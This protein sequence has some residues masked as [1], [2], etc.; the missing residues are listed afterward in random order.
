MAVR[1]LIFDFDGLILDTET[2]D[3]M[4][5]RKSL[6]STSWSLTMLSGASSWDATGACSMLLRIW[7]SSWASAWI[8]KSSWLVVAS[9]A[10]R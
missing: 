3:L 8:A 4:A 5:W 9:A 10:W 2:P 1:A 7:N 6:L